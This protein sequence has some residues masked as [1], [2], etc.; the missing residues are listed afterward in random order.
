MT[1]KK[2]PKVTWGEPKVTWEDT[3]ASIDADR[4]AE[5][6]EAISGLTQLLGAAREGLATTREGLG[7]ARKE[8][9]EWKAKAEHLSSLLDKGYKK[10]E[11]LEAALAD[12]RV[13]D[14]VARRLFLHDADNLV[15]FRELLDAERA[16]RVVSDDAITGP[17]LADGTITLE[18]EAPTVKDNTKP[19]P[20]VEGLDYAE[21][22]GKMARRA[23]ARWL[24][25]GAERDR[26]AFFGCLD[27][28]REWR[29][30]S[31]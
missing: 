13:R 2:E 14:A 23:F 22:L 26:D 19:K 31:R 28:L 30:I 21:M 1:D 29:S 12:L 25:K 5:L 7:A 11:K 16:A 24:E 18:M 20:E 15:K 3:Q 8:A 9:A 10:R 17:K 6:T 4:V 27:R